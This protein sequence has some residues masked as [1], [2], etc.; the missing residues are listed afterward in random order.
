MDIFN[1]D[2]SIKDF[3]NET[4]KDDLGSI[5]E[6]FKRGLFSIVLSKTKQFREEHEMDPGLERILSLV[7][8][9]CY[10]QIGEGKHAAEIIRIM[11]ENSHDKSIDDLILYGNLAFMCDY[12]L[13]RRI[14]SD[15]VKQLENEE[16]FD[17]LK[18]AH[19][20][21]ALGE[22]EENLEKYVRAIKYYKKGLSFFPE[23]D[24]QMILFLHYKLG[25]LHSL[26]NETGEA[27]EYLQKTIELTGENNKEI[28]I[29]SL[30]SIAKMYG[31][32]DEYEKAFTYLNEAIP[33]FEG[34][35]LV[36]KLVHAEA[37]TEMAFNYFDQSQLDEAIPYYK[38]AI[39]IHRQLPQYSARELGMIY[40]QYAYCN[41][42]KEQP[43][44]SLA[45]KNYE[46]AIE[47]L[48][49]ANDMALLENALAD[50][51]AFFGSIGNNKKKRFYENKFVKLTN[52]KAHSGA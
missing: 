51:I 47:Q 26:I 5:V 3:I 46:K 50:I 18:T 1:L 48:E 52:E 10:S 40:M 29:N 7:D 25:A 43:D 35:S 23:E 38:K 33:M 42:H 49:K 6:E 31:S 41:E 30:V 15:A 12:K 27:I 19:A 44:K 22:A 28:K 36:N 2:E 39:A 4:N 21:L 16:G 24:K 13:T 9:T 20:Y 37:Y 45:A 14:M 32:K 8:A 17:R 11:Y 34:S